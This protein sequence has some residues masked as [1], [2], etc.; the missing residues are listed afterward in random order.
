MVSPRFQLYL[1]A[2]DAEYETQVCFVQYL[3]S[4]H[5]Y[6]QSI[7]DAHALSAAFSGSRCEQFAKLAGRVHDDDT[8]RRPV[9][10]QR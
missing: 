8:G 9:L 7:E 3:L 5:L 10:N 1:S 6:R 2:T 4:L